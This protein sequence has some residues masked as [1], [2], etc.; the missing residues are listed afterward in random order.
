M[1]ID[2]LKN[3]SNHKKI[4]LFLKILAFVSIFI[5]FFRRLFKDYNVLEF[6][7][8]YAFM[9]PYVPLIFNKINLYILIL[10]LYILYISYC[11]AVQLKHFKSIQIKYLN[12]FVYF[13]S[14][15]LLLYFLLIATSQQMFLTFLI[16]IPLGIFFSYKNKKSFL[17]LMIKY[18]SF[19]FIIQYV[20]YQ[21]YYRNVFI[22]LSIIIGTYFGILLSKKYLAPSLKIK[23]DHENKVSFYGGLELQKEFIKLKIIRFQRFLKRSFHSSMPIVISIVCSFLFLLI[24]IPIGLNYGKYS[25]VIDGIWDMK[26]FYLT[27][28]IITSITSITSSEK[29]HHEMLIKQRSIYTDFLSIANDCSK[30]LYSDILAIEE[31]D[32]SYGMYDIP[33]ESNERWKSL[34]TYVIKLEKQRKNQYSSNV[35]YGTFKKTIIDYATR[36]NDFKS[37]FNENNIVGFTTHEYEYLKDAVHLLTVITNIDIKNEQYMFIV[38]KQH[39]EIFWRLEYAVASLRRPWTWDLSYDKKINKMIKS[40]L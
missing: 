16:H 20:S 31:L 7:R 3:I 28:I 5:L 35:D 15:V 18:I 21:F 39:L 12:R 4:A 6:D 9:T 10:L 34:Y 19:I 14:L 13:Y 1:K 38:A 27:S 36:L 11:T 26:S 32:D 23:I 24:I 30:F 8:I 2:N 22:Y 33:Y 37:F 25:S 40:Y 29:K 17:F